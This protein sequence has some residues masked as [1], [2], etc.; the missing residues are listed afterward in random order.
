MSFPA[1]PAPAG[2]PP[3]R[4]AP[5]WAV[6]LI[7]VGAIVL[8]GVVFV[9]GVL[10]GAVI[11]RDDAGPAAGGPVVPPATGG[12][13]SSEGGSGGTGSL[14]ECLV[15]SW[16]GT[17]HTEDWKTDQGAAQLSGLLRSMTFTA[18][19][20]QTITY[21]GD[22]AT[23]TAQG[24]PVPAVF[25]GQVVYRTSTSGDTMSFQLVS[26]EGTVTVDPDGTDKV[27]DLEPGTADVGYSCDDT[28]L[29]QEAEGYLSVYRRTS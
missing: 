24:T 14:D 9:G 8:L 6:V 20:T 25:D 15:G 16:E 1:P 23:I 18:D 22:Q 13:G 28:T 5:T 2:P 19:G 17:E 7:T 12:G 10:T 29:R 11:T 3:R 4:Q 26:A 21:D 27:E